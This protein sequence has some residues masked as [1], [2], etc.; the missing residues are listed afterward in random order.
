MNLVIIKSSFNMSV[1]LLDFG[2][3]AYLFKIILIMCAK[4]V[5]WIFEGIM[6]DIKT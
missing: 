4:S 2:L 6:Y 3:E 1:N 5:I